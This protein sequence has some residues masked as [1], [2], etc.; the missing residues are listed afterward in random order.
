MRKKISMDDIARDLNIS[1]STISFIINGK[2]KEMRISETLTS[3]VLDYVK[4]KNYNRN[5]LAQ[6]LRTGK[7]N[8]IGL[9][10]EDIADAFFSSVA[11]LIEERAYKKGY[12]IIYC[13]TED[14]PA[15]TAELIN[16]FKSRHVDGYII[17]APKGIDNEVALLLNEETPFV[18][19]DRYLP[20][21]PTDYVGIDNFWGAKIAVEHLASQGFKHIA[22]VTLDSEQTQMTDRLNGYNTAIID[23]SLL[24]HVLK[25]PFSL[26]PAQ[27]VQRIRK[28]IKDEPH[29]DA[30]LFATNY[31]ALQGFEALHKLKL[32][33][34][35][36]VA[37]IGFDDHAFFK[38]FNPPVTAVAQPMK[39]LSEKLISVLFKRMNDE[40]RKRTKHF[41]E[42]LKPELIIRESSKKPA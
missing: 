26:T 39:A 17:T 37:V 40:D 10:V 6:S 31:L 25:I 15:K 32:R 36:D 42:I 23:A 27:V 16:M 19:F 38:V 8:I 4:E 21:I 28:F 7:S 11:R 35:E 1:K 22:F 29:T 2:A 41:R 20:E 13:S 33:I 12:K 3:R 18:L 30:I 14:D 34:P 9:I 24:P 5:T